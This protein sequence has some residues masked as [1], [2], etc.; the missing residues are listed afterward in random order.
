MRG[1]P[2]PHAQSD[3]WLGASSDPMI[4]ASPQMKRETVMLEDCRVN[5]SHDHGEEA[6]EDDIPPPLI[7]PRPTPQL[8]DNY[9]PLFEDI[10]SAVANLLSVTN[11]TDDSTDSVLQAIIP[12]SSVTLKDV[13]FHLRGNISDFP[14]QKK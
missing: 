3:G 13:Y 14:D 6:E 5:L 7:H 11:T 8:G 4:M 2:P 9:C 10:L 12:L 1:L